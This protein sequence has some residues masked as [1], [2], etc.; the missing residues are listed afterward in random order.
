LQRSD[1]TG[2]I[3]LYQQAPGSPQPADAWLELARVG[4]APANGQRLSLRAWR[5]AEAQRTRPRCSSWPRPGW[6]RRLARRA[7]ALREYLQIA[8]DQPW[9]AAAQPYVLAAL[10]DAYVAV[11]AT[12]LA[13]SAYD[14]ANDAGLPAAQRA[15]QPEQLARALAAGGALDD[16]VGAYERLIAAAGDE[17]ER[18]RLLYDVAQLL[19]DNG[20]VDEGRARLRQILLSLTAHA[21]AGRARTVSRP[22]KRS[23]IAPGVRRLPCRDYTRAIPCFGRR[24]TG[25]TGSNRYYLAIALG[26]ENRPTEALAELDLELADA[27]AD[28][29]WP[30]ARIERVRQLAALGRTGEALAAF[31]E[32]AAGDPGLRW[33]AADLAMATNRYDEARTRYTDLAAAQRQAHL[34]VKALL[35]A[36]AA[37]Y[38]GPARGRGRDLERAAARL[39]VCRATPRHPAAAR[40]ERAVGG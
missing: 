25:A 8:E 30:L 18:G 12:D 23:T 37:A 17:A 24:L 39:P 5:D 4:C 34:K 36:G 28:D 33:D 3:A 15:R 14:R 2:A 29:L 21:R 32:L 26:A 35:R 19:L 31:D 7:R 40:Q 10:G 20:R 22:V 38:L 11:G 13:R 27:Q 9:S 16:A 1:D 6:P